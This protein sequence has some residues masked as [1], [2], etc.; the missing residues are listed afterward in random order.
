MMLG[1]W[2]VQTTCPKAQVACACGSSMIRSELMVHNTNHCRLRLVDCVECRTKVRFDEMVAHSHSCPALIVGCLYRSEGCDARQPRHLMLSHHSTCPFALISCPVPSVCGAR[3]LRR[4]MDKHLAE[5]HGR[6][7]VEELKVFLFCDQRF[8]W[9]W[10]RGRLD[11]L[12]S[13]A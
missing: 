9:W 4:E 11:L 1:E 7:V 8:H 5:S 10:C 12:R 6:W 3:I 13:E 2:G